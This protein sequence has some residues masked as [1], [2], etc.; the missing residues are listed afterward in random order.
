MSVNV[1]GICSVICLILFS[2]CL[3]DRDQSRPSLI[4]LPVVV[5]VKRGSFQLD[6]GTRIVYT[7][8]ELASTAQ[9]ASALVKPSEVFRPEL[10]LA[11]DERD[12]SNVIRLPLLE[13]YDG[14]LGDE[15]YHLLVKKA[16][17]FISANTAAG[18]FYCIQTLKNEFFWERIAVL[19]LPQVAIDAVI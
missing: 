8:R 12:E 9:F 5:D 3:E 15:G 10:H 18:L 11:P 2:G 1:Q 6:S 7:S 4:P 13:E 14:I 17:I 16:G 19:L